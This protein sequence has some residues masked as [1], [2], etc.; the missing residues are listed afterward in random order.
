MFERRAVMAPTPACRHLS[1]KADRRTQ[2]DWTQTPLPEREMGVNAD[3]NETVGE[4]G[5]AATTTLES[6]ALR[7]T[8]RC[9]RRSADAVTGHV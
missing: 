2:P 6:H 8:F 1:D 7:S 5:P 9:S 4:T 3:E